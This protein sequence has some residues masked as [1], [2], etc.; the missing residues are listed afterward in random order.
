MI[1]IKL[2]GGLGNNMFQYASTKSLAI[3]KNLRFCYFP[4]RDFN[5]YKQQTI[6]L[7]RIILLNKRDKFQKQL[8]QRDISK[9]FRIEEK[10]FKKNINRLLW[11]IKNKNKKNFFY[12][13]ITIKDIENKKQVIDKKFFNCTPW[14][15]II[16]PLASEKYFLERRVI[17][18]WFTPKKYYEGKIEQI[19]KKFLFPPEL[20]C[21]VH[22]RRGD[23]LYMDK[24]YDLNGLGWGLPIEYYS[25]IM[26]NLSKN[27][28]Y[29][30]VSDD[31]DWVE[32]NLNFYLIKSF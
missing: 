10:F 27:I 28:L 16:G 6:K 31:P 30:F 23:A 20:R 8:S 32:K 2:S 29:I 11:L 1:V 25:S 9:Y 12:Q 21:C 19:E 14:T 15:Q 5:F 22:V 4:L 7:L 13:N 26:K 3:S 18:S 24:G 17:L